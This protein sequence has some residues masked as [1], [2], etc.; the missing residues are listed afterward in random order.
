MKKIKALS[1]LIL[2][3]LYTWKKANFVIPSFNNKDADW[4]IYEPTFFNVRTLS[5]DNHQRVIASYF[6]LKEKK[7]S[8]T[9]YTKKDIGIFSNKKILFFGEALNSYKFLDHSAVVRFVS[10]NLIKQNNQVFPDPH[11]AALWENKAYMHKVFDE[12]NIRTPMSTI[13]YLNNLQNEELRNL[14]YPLLIKEEHSCSAFGVHKLNSYDEMINLLKTD[15]VSSMN[16]RVICQELLNIKRDL[17]VI[18]VGEK[19]VLHYWRI[20][21]ADEWKPTSTGHGSEVDFVTFPEQCRGWIMDTFKRL[22]MKTG[23]FDI[24]WQNDDFESEPYILE[25]SPFYQPNPKPYKNMDI[26]Y[27]DWKKTV[28]LKNSYLF[29]FIDVMF[30][31]Q[32]EL[33]NNLCKQFNDSKIRES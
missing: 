24:A 18:I 6:Y 17:R 20:N 2:R 23:A 8:V 25:V 19:I 33:V 4:I 13:L 32:E 16:D 9:I 21:L 12:R 1:K 15:K 27:G 22:D 26:N 10:E 3:V 11:E 30:D 29:G 28:S 14:S 5:S 31:I 7:N